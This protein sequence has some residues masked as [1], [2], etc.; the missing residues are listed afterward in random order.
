VKIAELPQLA[1]AADKSRQL[2]REVARRLLRAD[3]WE[4]PSMIGIDELE[5]VLGPSQV[6]Q[7][8]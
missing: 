4:L 8:M 5:N 6:F 1:I 7:M 3:W 2:N